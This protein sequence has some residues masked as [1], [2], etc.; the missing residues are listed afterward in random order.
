MLVPIIHSNYFPLGHDIADY[1]HSLLIQDKLTW[2]KPAPGL[3][4]SIHFFLLFPTLFRHLFWE[5]VENT[6]NLPQ[7]IFEPQKSIHIILVVA[8]VTLEAYFVVLVGR[9]GIGERFW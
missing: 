3:L 6:S 1:V 9:E 4:F 5:K 2:H 8:T 7:S